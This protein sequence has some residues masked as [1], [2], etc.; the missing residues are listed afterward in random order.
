MQDKT[1]INLVSSEISGLWFTYTNDTMAI[2]MLKYFLNRVEDEEIRPILQYALN[3][4]NSHIQII[5]NKLDE[6]GLPAPQGFKE[7]DVNINA[8]RLYTDS[9]YLFYLGRLS[10]FGMNNYTQI[11]GYTSRPDT[12]DFFSKCIGESVNLYNKVAEVLQSQGLL[13]RAPSVEL[14]KQI[15]FIDKQNFFNKGLLG[16]NRPLLAQEITAIFVSLRY[17]VI[18]GALITGFAQVT[19]SKRLNDFFFKGRDIANGKI[20]KLTAILL[21]EKIPIPST[22]DS[23]VTD[24]TTAPFSDKLM[25]AHITIL[26][27]MSIGQDSIAL[28]NV[29]RH[30][31]HAYFADSITESGKVAED[32]LDIMIE[33]Q[34]MEQP[35]QVINHE[36]LV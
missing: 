14:S 11:L 35:P 25:L 4:S 17:N 6:E 12:R 32:G 20:K 36:A 19:K 16:R 28:S 15:D 26:Y 27:S 23:F 24:S 3:I 22:S 2:C 8:P 5:T 18:G 7:E 33:N 29:L 9:F 34:W 10:T 21:N 13:V 31:L 30:D 1:K